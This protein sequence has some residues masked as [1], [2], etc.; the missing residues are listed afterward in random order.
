MKK[1]LEN[2]DETLLLK[3]L[4][5]RADDTEKVQF[6]EWQQKAE[7]AK[8]FAEFKKAYKISSFDSHST[9][10]NWKQ[11]VHKVEA[12]YKVPDFIELPESMSKGRTIKLNPLLRVA[13]VI[14]VLIAL[15]FLFRNIVFSP[16]QLIVSA[17]DLKKNEAFQLAD[18]SNVYLN[19]N[20]EIRFAKNFGRKNRDI[21]LKGEA[22]FEVERNEDLAFQIT[23]NNT[24]TRVLGTSFNVF[25]DASGN[26]KVSV[27]TGVVEFFSNKENKVEL[28]AGEQGI[29][30]PVISEIK[31]ESISDLNFNSWK[32]GVLIFEET[33]LLEVF[34]SLGLYFSKVIILESEKTTLPNITTTFDNQSFEA[35]LE[36]LNLLL[37][38]KNEFRNDTIIFKPTN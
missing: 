9:L 21:Y 16:E 32:T 29:Y 18:G 6:E 38:T 28:H 10:E 34:T 19:G 17:N 24:T 8:M 15:G 36:E 35:V 1:K 37:N 14:I 11:V 5:N 33:P 4:E 2:I 7:Y 13:A 20:A 26:V 12:G 25:S 3:I 27:V 22:F 30:N 31:K 23:T